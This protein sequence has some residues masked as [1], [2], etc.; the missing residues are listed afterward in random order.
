MFVRDLYAIDIPHMS[1]YV[2]GSH[3]LGILRKHMGQ[4]EDGAPL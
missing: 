3:A 4:N 1:R 2:A